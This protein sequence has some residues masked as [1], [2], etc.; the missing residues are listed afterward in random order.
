M[1]SLALPVV[2]TYLGLMAMALVDLLAVG[3]VGAVAVGA[4]G[5]GS[6]IFNW[7]MIFGIGLLSGLEY[8][9]SH[10]IGA[11]RHRDARSAFA[12]GMIVSVALGIP[13][14]A[15]IV[16]LSYKLSWFGISE[17]VRPAAAS[18]LR[19]LAFSLTPVYVFTGARQYLQARGIAQPALTILI[20]ANVL[21][22]LANY[23]LVFGNWGFPA[24]GSDGSAWATSI[25]RLWMMLAAFGYVLLR[26]REGSG[27]PRIPRE[28]FGYH[29]PSLRE[30]LHLGFP[31]ALQMTFEVGVFALATIL[32]G[33]L[34]PDALAAHQ[35]VLNIASLTFMVPLGIGSAAAV[36]VGQAGGR[37]DFR[38]AR[39]L[40]WQALAMGTGFMSLSAATLYFFSGAILGFYT[41][42]PSV[43]LLAQ[44][45]ILVAAFFQISDGAQVVAAGC[46]RGLG[47]TRTAMLTNLFGHWALGLPIGVALCYGLGWGIVG[48]WNGLSLGLTAVA[49]VLVRRWAVESRIRAA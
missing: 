22:A 37:R 11:G 33:G 35:I 30:L 1:F 20:L 15:A 46:L 40:G 23:V 16:L 18:Y 39:R 7:F 6:S 47:N 43:I 2:L 38:E 34:V 44:K 25:A 27:A 32:A 3:R 36:L 49:I 48:L 8:L 21:N 42:V 26:E 31:A 45:I 14:T 19:I 29:G 13:A 24:L 4:V 41:T 9:V 12:Q 17:E 5:I 10:A 28:L